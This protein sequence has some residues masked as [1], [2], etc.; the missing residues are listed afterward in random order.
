MPAHELNGIVYVAPGRQGVSML[1]ALGLSRTRA[2]GWIWKIKKG[3]ILPPE[4]QLIQD[5]EG[6]YLLVPTRLM[7]LDEFRAALTGLA[8]HAERFMKLSEV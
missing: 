5:H 7:P 4:L 6:H 1:D 8:V 3:T 2:D